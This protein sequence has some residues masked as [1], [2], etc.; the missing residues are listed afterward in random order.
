ML[1]ALG[2]AVH[3][4]GCISHEPASPGRLLTSDRTVQ[5][6]DSAW[7]AR[8]RDGLPQML[9]AVPRE[10]PVIRCTVVRE[11]VRLIPVE[12]RETM[13]VIAKRQAGVG[14]VFE[15]GPKGVE[16]ARGGLLVFSSIGG[17]T[18]PV[19]DSTPVG[20]APNIPAPGEV[21]GVGFDV[22]EP[23][24]APCRGV[25]IQLH[26]LGGVEY[27]QPVTE[28]L[29]QHG[30]LIL[31]AEF[32]WH[33][34]RQ[35][36]IELGSEAELDAVAQE[37]ATM[38]DDCQAEMA[39]AVEGVLEHLWQTRPDLARKPVILLGFSAGS[40]TV[41]TIAARLGDRVAGVV[42][43]GSGCNVV[44]IVQTSDLTDG[45]LRIARDGHRITGPLAGLLA[46]RYIGKTR[47]DPYHTAAC[48]RRRPVLMIHA[49][50]D[51]IVPSETGQEL[52]ERLDR[53]ERLVIS[54][55]H[56]TLFM[57]VGALGERIAA[58]VDKAAADWSPKGR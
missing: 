34:W 21:H 55:G 41:P 45:G 13:T 5:L 30:Y 27:E 16:S 40:V 53:P 51:T 20:S 2:C 17:A 24:D 28:A 47:L 18:P 57:Q 52:Y 58:W 14:M 3:L 12:A 54:G 35:R 42:L 9:A 26:G 50:A 43:A 31:Q 23:A 49:N 19:D 38:I 22:I 36:H 1:A 29:S 56:R 15:L 4:S 44:Q 48:L 39:Y 25:V 33:R 8:E 11:K 32:P 46:G 37:L 7:P 6:P 10:A